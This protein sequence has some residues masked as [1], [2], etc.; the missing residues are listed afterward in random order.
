MMGMWAGG[1]DAAIARGVAESVQAGDA[2]SISL[3]QAKDI[4]TTA[5]QIAQEV[6]GNPIQRAAVLRAQLQTAIVEQRPLSTIL[7]L[8]AKVA[9]ADRQVQAYMLGEQSSQEWANLGKIGLAVSI[10]VG[11]ALMLLLAT[12]AFK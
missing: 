6:T 5:I 11:A 12:R 2:S 7:E 1:Q 9:A 10:G 3:A 8:R 4:T